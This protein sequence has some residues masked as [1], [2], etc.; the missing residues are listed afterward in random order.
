MQL[1]YFK[2]VRNLTAVFKSSG[3]A[4]VLA[5]FPSILIS[6]P[7][8]A[9]LDF[10]S[11]RKEGRTMFWVLGAKPSIQDMVKLIRRAWHSFSLP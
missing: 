5:V 2:G 6:M 8:V 11:L 4:R 9:Y 3:L 1:P 10:L 7:I